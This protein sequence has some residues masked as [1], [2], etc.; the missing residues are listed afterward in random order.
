MVH[1]ED[2]RAIVP[3]RARAT[4]AA[5]PHARLQMIARAGHTSTV[6]EPVAVTNALAQ[7]LDEQTA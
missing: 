4:A 1:G 3:P 5:I 2:D 6:E 7:F